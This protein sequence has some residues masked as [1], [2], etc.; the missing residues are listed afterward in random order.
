MTDVTNQHKYLIDL[1]QQRQGNGQSEQPGAQRVFLKC[2][3]ESNSRM[4]SQTLDHNMNHGRI[5][6][7]LTGLR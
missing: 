2:F 3:L 4:T 1:E 6:Q 7:R 5:N